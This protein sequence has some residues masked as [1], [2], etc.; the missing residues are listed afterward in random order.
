MITEQVFY[1]QIQWAGSWMVTRQRVSERK[2][3]EDHPEAV[4]VDGSEETVFIP[5]TPQER[6]QAVTKARTPG[7]GIRYNLT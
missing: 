2:I 1:W 5:E 7:P 3:R 4:K 6:M